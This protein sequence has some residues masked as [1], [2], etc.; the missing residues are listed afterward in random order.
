ML[1]SEA[2]DV[3]GHDR[4]GLAR[5]DAPLPSLNGRVESPELFGDGPGGR[6]AELMA[7]EAAVGFDHIKPLALALDLCWD[8]VAAR[9]RAGSRERAG[10][11]DLQ[12]GIPV[13]GRIVLRRCGRVRRYGSPQIKQVAGLRLHLGRVYEAKAPHPDGVVGLREIRNDIVPVVIGDHDLGHPGRQVRG[14]RDD[15]DA[16]LWPVRA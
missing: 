2:A 5:L 6:I 4:H 3:A 15:P 1:R 9:P 14:L 10:G 11:W 7:G 13:Y 16:G 12:H 8:A